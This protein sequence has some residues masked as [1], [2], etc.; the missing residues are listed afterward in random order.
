LALR[1]NPHINS[2]PPIEH[3]GAGYAGLKET[4]GALDFSTCCNPYG[5]PR[6]VYRALRVTNITDYPDPGSCELVASL[7]G[8]LEIAA[9]RVIAGSGS[10]EI[11]RLAALAYLTTGDT[12]I[13]V[14]PTYGEYELASS[15]A[16]STIVKYILPE[17]RDFRLRLDDFASFAQAHNPGAVF[18]CNPNNPTGQLLP[19]E[20]L[21]RFVKGFPDTLIMLD[22]AYM[23]FTGKTSGERDLADEPNVLIVRSMTK[24]FALAG[25]RLGY[26]LACPA[27]IRSLEKVRPPWNVNSPAQRA[28]IAAMGCGDYVRQ[29]ND[30][31]H[32]SRAY[33]TGRLF[34]IGYRTIPT[35]THFFL[36]RVG[37]AAG[38]KSSL[39]A[40]GFLVRDCSSFG[41][42]AY[43]R[44]SP[45]RMED[46]R[47]LAQAISAMAWKVD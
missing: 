8:N 46:C 12:V 15:I 39:L 33:L 34:K 42:P 21:R 2:L 6:E 26:G 17:D 16:G 29:C 4:A 1:V 40:R 20:D 25:L 43:V 27:I 36:V 32:K 5:P 10:T 9:D 19:R 18:L 7:A 23:A 41:L 47:K 30:R 38:F 22:E 45:R 13:I 37:D 11:I 24:D 44:I 3:G 31:M 14:S 28:G 35:D